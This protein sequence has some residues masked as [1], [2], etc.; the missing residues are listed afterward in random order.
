MEKCGTFL[1]LRRCGGMDIQPTLAAKLPWAARITLGIILL[2]A[3]AGV[4]QPSL[5]AT[6][7]TFRPDQISHALIIY[8][9]TLL[10]AVSF[11]RIK[12][13]WLALFFGCIAVGVEVAQL[14]KIVPGDAQISDVVADAIGILAALLP[15][16]AVRARRVARAAEKIQARNDER[17]RSH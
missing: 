1:L 16:A 3:L 4:V 15:I 2:L 9:V 12:P 10:S 6:E 13:I 7:F 17:H 11:P 5:R 8:C 14:Y